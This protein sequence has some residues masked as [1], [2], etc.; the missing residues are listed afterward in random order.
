L[1]PKTPKPLPINILIMEGS[2]NMTERMFPSVAQPPLKRI[3]VQEVYGI[4]FAFI[5]RGR[6]QTKL[7]SPYDPHALGR[8]S[9]KKLIVKIVS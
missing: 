9:P 5:V 3:G 4:F 2:R 1:L 6:K 7:E 8:L